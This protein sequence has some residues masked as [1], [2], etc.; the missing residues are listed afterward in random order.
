MIPRGD[1]WWGKKNQSINVVQK[2]ETYKGE[3]SKETNPDQ[4]Q[5][6]GASMIGKKK[7]VS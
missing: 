4:T 3:K 6:Q 5:T 1:L 7:F 2:T